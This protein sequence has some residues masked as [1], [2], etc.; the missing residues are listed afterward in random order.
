[1]LNDFISEQVIINMIK[2]TVS[3]S[4]YVNH[5][6]PKVNY[7]ARCETMISSQTQLIVCE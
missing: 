5:N 6:V 1:M 3:L 4:E 2:Q 7:R